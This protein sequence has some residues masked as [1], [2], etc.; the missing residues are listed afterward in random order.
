MIGFLIAHLYKPKI[1]I[2][3]SPSFH[4]TEEIKRSDLNEANIR[5][6][7][8]HLLQMEIEIDSIDAW[9][10]NTKAKDSLLT[11]V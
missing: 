7:T 6:N 3:F 1:K 10:I 5:N 11:M 4:Y 2:F 8:N 9:E